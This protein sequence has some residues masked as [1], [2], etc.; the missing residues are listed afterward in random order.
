MI[1]EMIK[2]THVLF[3]Q[4]LG[5]RFAVV[6][7]TS[8]GVWRWWQSRAGHR[9]DEVYDKELDTGVCG[10]CHIR[11]VQVGTHEP[12][13]CDK[14]HTGHRDR[15]HENR[16]REGSDTPRRS[17]ERRRPSQSEQLP[18]QLRTANPS[19][20]TI[21]LRRFEADSEHQVSCWLGLET[22]KKPRPPLLQ[23]LRLQGNQQ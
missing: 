22:S 3:L 9:G 5:A 2:K 13:Q 17:T 11:A 23:H 7:L 21:N 15:T 19:P 6:T 8:A 20:G 10:M 14:E 12:T 18:Q 1:I 4:S 16:K